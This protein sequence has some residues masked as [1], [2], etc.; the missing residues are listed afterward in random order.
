MQRP[1]EAYWAGVKTRLLP[2]L[3]VGLVV[4]VVVWWLFDDGFAFYG[5]LA[6]FMTAAL[7]PDRP[8]RSHRP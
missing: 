5:G 3:L 8:S 4:A 7:M 2:A 1:G 6:S